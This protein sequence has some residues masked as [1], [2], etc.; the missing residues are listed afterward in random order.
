MPRRT[1][2]SE[3]GW[4]DIEAPIDLF[5]AITADQRRYGTPLQ[6]CSCGW[7]PASDDRAEL[8]RHVQIH[9]RKATQLLADEDRLKAALADRQGCK[10][11]V[12]APVSRG[13]DDVGRALVRHECG[14]DAGR[15]LLQGLVLLH[16]WPTAG[17][18]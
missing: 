2:A 1:D 4:D 15:E 16:L 9:D 18:R 13:V 5:I 10:C 17:V 14:R 11:P 7:R 3:Y 8:E 12:F 6:P